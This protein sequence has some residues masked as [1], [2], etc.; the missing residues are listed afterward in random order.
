MS[1][2]RPNA[3]QSS[4][5]PV[6]VITGASSGIGRATAL[7]FAAQGA[8]LVLA[9]RNKTALDAVA[10]DCAHE[11]ARSFV[12]PTDVTDADAVQALADAALRHFGRIDVW[13]NNVGVGAVGRFEDTPMASH[14]RVVEANLLGHMNGAHA[15]L[16]HFRAQERGVLIN[17]VSAGGW[18][19]TPYAGAYAASKFGLRGWSESLRAE[20][21][22]LPGVHVCEVYPTFVDT[23]GVSHG[24]NYTGKRLRP[25]PPLSDPR[26]VAAVLVRLARH[27]RPVVT[28]GAPALPGR[29]AHAIAPN[30]LARLL[31]WFFDAG[32]ARAE[33]AVATDG[34]LFTPSRGA[35]IDGGFRKRRTVKPATTLA[36]VLA[37]AAASYAAYAVIE[38]RRRR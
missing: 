35:A 13:I 21:A 11:G 29:L 27:P 9:A 19:A 7:A 28:I 22:D 6:V 4:A 36:L 17:M 23:P 15:V 38:A 2:I 24:A 30:L 5:S 32:L 12:L 3:S 16:P 33:P 8:Q 20:L 1:K 14:R 25:P 26:R 18:V 37:A 31:K 10:Q 34:N